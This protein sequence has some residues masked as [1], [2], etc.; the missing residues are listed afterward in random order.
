MLCIFCILYIQYLLLSEQI[1]V[2]WNFL[3]SLFKQSVLLF[4]LDFI[5]QIVLY[6]FFFCIW[7]FCIV[8]F[9]III[10]FCNCFDWHFFVLF[11]YPEFYIFSNVI[12]LF[13][14]LLLSP[15]KTILVVYFAARSWSPDGPGLGVQ[16][17][18]N[19]CILYIQQLVLCVF[20]F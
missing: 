20:Y 11:I 13:P 14:F 6:V 7:C 10:C 1:F 4:V 18:R 17:P 12:L 8:Y 19:F 15:K 5:L 2:L 9:L 16:G 3:L